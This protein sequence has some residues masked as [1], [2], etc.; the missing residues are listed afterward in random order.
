MITKECFPRSKKELVVEIIQG[1]DRFGKYSFILYWRTNYI[2]GQPEL[3]HPGL[4][5]AQA[6]H[7][8]IDEILCGRKYRTVERRSI[9]GGE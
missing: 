9:K 7:A 8:S 1:P 2:P 6:F 5:R 3:S 4:V